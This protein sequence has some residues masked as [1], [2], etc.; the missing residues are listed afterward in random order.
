MKEKK[1][2]EYHSIFVDLI[3]SVE[4]KFKDLLIK[5]SKKFDLLKQH[6]YFFVFFYFLI[7]FYIILVFL[8]ALNHNP[9]FELDES[10]TLNIARQSFNS[11]GVI[12]SYEQNFPPYYLLLKTLFNLFGYFEK[13]AVLFNFSLW[14]ISIAFF[15]KL[16]VRFI[17]NKHWVI[18]FTFLYLILPNL[19]YYSFSVRMYQLLNVCVLAILYLNSKYL[20]EKRLY[21]IVTEGFISLL[22][23]LLHPIAG[24]LLVAIFIGNLLIVQKKH[25]LTVCI[26]SILSFLLYFLQLSFKLNGLINFTR[27]IEYISNLNYSA[28]N[29][30]PNALSIY[31]LGFDAILSIF[32]FSLLAIFIKNTLKQ[33]KYFMLNI[34]VITFS[35]LVLLAYRYINIQH[36][37]V[38]TGPFILSLFIGLY[39]LKKYRKLVVTFLLLIFIQATVNFFGAQTAKELSYRYACQSLASIKSGTFIVDYNLINGLTYCNK[40]NIKIIMWGGGKITDIA[41]TT[42]LNILI[43]QA[44]FGGSPLLTFSNTTINPLSSINYFKDLREKPADIY[45]Y[46]HETY[47]SSY[48]LGLVPRGYYFQELLYPTIFHFTNKSSP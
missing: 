40:H 6:K 1:H 3:E 34:I 37:V 4:S 28:L 30:V 48:E 33:A 31:P 22:I 19:T 38:F 39:L 5:I 26:F 7:G 9:N 12:L 43:D 47:L 2:S 41:K 42:K 10:N 29:L 14:L 18:F 25:L 16:L 15:Y 24:I 46:T 20:E 11:I 13:I 17:K 35:F 32:Y 44:K 21:L 45:L 27:G 8:L 23:S 36:L